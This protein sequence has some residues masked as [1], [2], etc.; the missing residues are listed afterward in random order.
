MGIVMLVGTMAGIERGAQIVMWLE[1]LGQVGKVVRW[2]YVVFLLLIALMVFSDYFKAR[3]KKKLG[4]DVSEN[5]C[6]PNWA[7]PCT[8]A[9]RTL[10]I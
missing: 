1:R 9:S 6:W 3:K 7:G 8:M 5:C 10:K 2:V 4:V